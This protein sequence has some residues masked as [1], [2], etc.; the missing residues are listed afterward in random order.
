MLVPLVHAG[1]N[2]ARSCSLGEGQLAS[3]TLAA[4]IATAVL[5]VRRAVHEL[6]VGERLHLEARALR[7]G[8]QGACRRHSPAGPAGALF[9][10][11]FGTERLG[12][13]MA[14]VNGLQH[15]P[16]LCLAS[17]LQEG[18]GSR[19]ISI[20]A[21]RRYPGVVALVSQKGAPFLVG[22]VGEF[23]QRRDPQLVRTGIVSLHCCLSL[24]EDAEALLKAY[25]IFR[26]STEFSAKLL[27]LRGSGRRLRSGGRSRPSL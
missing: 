7:E 13:V 18:T 21:T 14:P 4:A 27:V 3:G 6:L 20:A 16:N 15:H 8:L 12:E 25:L 5:G 22:V 11:E 19:S 23:V 2:H 10:D 1:G 17:D 26:F 9:S 24:L